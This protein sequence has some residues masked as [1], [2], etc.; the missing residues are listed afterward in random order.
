M[1]EI[2]THDELLAA[3]GVYANLYRMTYESEQAQREQES[4]GEDAAI[5]RRRR[6]EVGETDPAG[7]VTVPA[8]GA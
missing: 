6:G 2:G 8:S 4:L 7:E 5:A 3:G 1:I